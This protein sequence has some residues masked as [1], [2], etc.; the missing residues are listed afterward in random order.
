MKK[1]ALCIFFLSIIGCVLSQTLSMIAGDTTNISY[2]KVL[3]PFDTVKERI[4]GIVDTKYLDINNDGHFDFLFLGRG[5]LPEMMGGSVNF[6]SITPLDSNAIIY[7]AMKTDTC[8]I[9]TTIPIV[10]SYIFNDTMNDQYQHCSEET[11]VVYSR[12]YMGQTCVNFFGSY[13]E[14]YI[15]VKLNGSSATG[16]A[17]LK[18]ESIDGGI[19]QG[20]I[21]IIKEYAF[22]SRTYSLDEQY[23]DLVNIFPNPSP[24]LVKIN[25]QKSHEP[26]NITLVDNVGKTILERAI[27]A[28]SVVLELRKG[29]YIL[30]VTSN[31]HKFITKK[32][33][34][35]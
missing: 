12:R 26:C 31:N 3:N 17:W 15:G 23:P 1:L 11:Y 13:G 2:H 30:Q 10:K 7:E 18:I 16:I 24:G 25:L 34:I 5:N 4:P 21:G 32:I 35:I 27:D 6:F 14:K 8:F 9:T 33:I 22:K 19:V 29:F 28:G 20:P